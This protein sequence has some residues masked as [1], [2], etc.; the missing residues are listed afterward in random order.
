MQTISAADLRAGA[1]QFTPQPDEYGSRY[2]SF[3]FRVSDG[4]NFS[5]ATGTIAIK[6]DGFDAGPGGFRY[7]DDALGTAIP[8]KADG[9]YTA[10]GGNAGGGLGIVLG[11]GPTGGATSGGW[12]DTFE[13]AIDDTVTIDLDYRLI[14]ASRFEADEFGEAVLLVDG[15]RF[16]SD[17]GDSLY[18]ATGD[19]NAGEAEDS[20][21]QSVSYEIALTAGTHTITLAAFNNQSTE[22]SEI[23]EVYY[24]NIVIRRPVYNTNELN[25]NAVDDAIGIL[26]D[27]DA[28]PNVVTENAAIGTTVG[29]TAMAADPDPQ[30][31]V[32]YSLDLDAGGRFAVNAVTGVIRVS[33]GLDFE[34]SATENLVVRATSTDGSSATQTVVISVTDVNESP[35]AL[36]ESYALD[37]G[38]SLSVSVPGVIFNDVDVD[39][40]TLSTVLV[41]G[42][43]HG[44]F[45]L[46]PGGDFTYTPNAGFFGRDFFLY[47]V[48]DGLLSSRI[49][50]ATIDVSGVVPDGV[51]SGSGPGAGSGT[52]TGSGSGSGGIGVSNG[53]SS[54]SDS[55]NPPDPGREVESQTETEML[56]S[57]ETSDANQPSAGGRNAL[58]DS[59]ESAR[60]AVSASENGTPSDAGEG[61][62]DRPDN[63]QY[64][65]G[66]GG[67]SQNGGGQSDG[68]H[69]SED[70]TGGEALGGEAELQFFI[71]YTNTES[72]SDGAFSYS[73]E[74]AQLE[75]VLRHD[76]AQAIVWSQWDN[77][78]HDEETPMS[79]FVGAAGAGMAVFSVGYVF[80][81]LRGGALMTV[82]GSSLPAWRFIDPIA[83]LSAYRSSRRGGDDKL[84]SLVG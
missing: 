48:S 38:A 51:G 18:R 79:V 61:E 10:D 11:R 35:T 6:N 13:L 39:G 24:D 83:M 15:V 19:G 58:Q 27:A 84:D 28:S 26:S 16:G 44:T 4:L 46:G 64:A 21:W 43:R 66:Q 14:F 34:T 3:G 73:P 52:G 12:T 45:S 60:T 65:G 57:T 78:H 37:S 77:A 40:D 53:G 7:F 17:M 9:R 71:L 80:W 59:S 54:E 23:V 55:A 29:V 47:R 20:G 81:A 25:V 31:R 30:D 74:L 2:D 36:G 67:G 68:S 70:P 72:V 22:P 62:G 63:G 69:N 5:A 56:E 32:S 82:F 76:L 1:L 75:R 42:P 50:R 8:G 33:G 41:L 49:V